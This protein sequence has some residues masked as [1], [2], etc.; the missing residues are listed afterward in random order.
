MN[1]PQYLLESNRNVTSD[2]ETG[3]L[4]HPLSAD[5]SASLR[6]AERCRLIVA[7]DREWRSKNE[8]Y[9]TTTARSN[10]NLGALQRGIAE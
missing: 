6:I 8:R 2:L 1:M 7:A 10:I 5:S 3:E 4:S 9:L